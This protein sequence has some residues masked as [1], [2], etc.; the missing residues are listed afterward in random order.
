[1][2]Q[3][4]QRA[5]LRQ[6]CVIV[7][8]QRFEQLV[9]RHHHRYGV[10]AQVAFDGGVGGQITHFISAV[11]GEHLAHESAQ[12]GLRRLGGRLRGGVRRRQRETALQNTV[13]RILN[14]FDLLD[15]QRRI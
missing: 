6:R 7:Q 4:S 15:R 10:D 14:G 11:G 8:A 5:A 3:L 1:M 13:E 2:L 9:A 12:P